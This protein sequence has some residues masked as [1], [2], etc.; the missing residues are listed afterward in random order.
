[1]ICMLAFIPALTSTSA[2]MGMWGR[3]SVPAPVWLKSARRVVGNSVLALMEV[4]RPRCT[5]VRVHGWEGARTREPPDGGQA[6]RT[7][8]EASRPPP[9]GAGVG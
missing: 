7:L 2:G 4:L 9:G 8:V 5:E 6:V 1:M 3:Q